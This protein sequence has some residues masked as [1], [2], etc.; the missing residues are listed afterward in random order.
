MGARP[1]LD[2]FRLDVGRHPA[3]EEFDA[4]APDHAVYIVRTDGHLAVANSRIGCGLYKGLDLR[5]RES[6][7]RTGG[8]APAH[9]WESP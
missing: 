8:R 1:R 9:F 2:H 6:R 7:V 4:A 5:F 3:P